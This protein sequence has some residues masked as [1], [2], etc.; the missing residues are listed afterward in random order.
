MLDFSDP[1]FW[2][3]PE[4]REATAAWISAALAEDGADRDV[5]SQT[6]LGDQDR[7]ATAT[8]TA[9][10]PGI[11]CGASPAYEV[12]RR[13]D[14]RAEVD[15]IPADGRSVGTGEE[16]L[17]VRAHPVPLLAAERTALNIF[18]SLSGIATQTGRW[19][20]LAGRTAVLDTRKTFP[21]ARLFQRRAVAAGGGTNHRYNLADFPL[22]KENHRSL[23]GNGGPDDIGEITRRLQEAVPGVPVQIEVEDE[24]SFRAALAAGAERILIDNQSPATMARWIE[25]AEADGLQVR[26]EDLEASGGITGETIA[27]YAASGV[28][29][30]SLGALT[31]TWKS[32]DFSL[33]VE[34][35]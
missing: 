15:S 32:F 23:F 18:G 33:H 35:A 13:L 16:V 28:G 20:A 10:M 12:F 11:L 4:V 31:H 9:G 25:N 19:V 22:V 27:D 7:L 6:L 26:R 24:E 34:W 3:V 5:T 21:G 2:N 30:V 8:I 29:R 17:V 1:E 14:P